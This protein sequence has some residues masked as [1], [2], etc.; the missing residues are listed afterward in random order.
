M[1]EKFEQ[2]KIERQ[3]AKSEDVKFAREAHHKA[4]YDTIVN[5]FGNWNMEAQDKFFESDWENGLNYEIILCNDKPCGYCSFEETIDN[6]ILNEIVI[7][8]EFQNRGIGS[9]FLQE[10]IDES[11]T[12]KIP[13]WLQVLK[14]NKAM[15]LY[16][17]FGFVKTGETETH[18]KMEFNPKKK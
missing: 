16:K 7:L 18:F 3:P 6:I 5:Q 11:K 15:D 1:S 17:R 4:Y 13:V 14:L 9:K 2:M 12:K 8:P 10:K